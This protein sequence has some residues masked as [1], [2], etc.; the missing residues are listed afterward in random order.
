MINSIYLNSVT[1]RLNTDMHDILLNDTEVIS[2]FLYKQVTENVVELELKIPSSIKNL[3][4]FKCRLSDGTIISNN[5][6]N[7]PIIRAE[8]TLIYRITVRGE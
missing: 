4:N 2:S 8:T 3:T 1:N 6:V 7:I 5:N